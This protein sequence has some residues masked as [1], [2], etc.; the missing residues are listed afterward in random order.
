MFVFSEK[1]SNLRAFQDYD[2]KIMKVTKNEKLH[3]NPIQ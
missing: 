2:K 3:P 1:K